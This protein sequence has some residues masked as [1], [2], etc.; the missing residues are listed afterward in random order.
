[1]VGILFSTPQEWLSRVSIVVS[2]PKIFSESDKEEQPDL[3]LRTKMLLPS[4]ANICRPGLEKPQLRRHP[5]M[6]KAVN[7]LW[8]K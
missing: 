2:M 4:S 3:V 1:M 5:T 8:G 6:Y 7:T